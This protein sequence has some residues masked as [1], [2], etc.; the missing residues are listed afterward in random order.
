MKNSSRWKRIEA[1][2]AE[3]F[4]TFRVPGSGSFGSRPQAKETGETKSDTMH[5]RLFIEIKHRT[6]CAVATWYQKTCEEAIAEGK[7]PM[8]GLHLKGSANYLVVCDVRDL[9]KIAEMVVD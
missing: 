4:G 9:K 2:F 5:D 8:L 1:I 6:S 7:I 3:F